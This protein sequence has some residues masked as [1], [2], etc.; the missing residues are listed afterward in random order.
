[1]QLCTDLNML[2]SLYLEHCVFDVTF[3]QSEPIGTGQP[4]KVGIFE[5]GS[6]MDIS[7]LQQRPLIYIQ[8]IKVVIS[9]SGG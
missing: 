3:L 4:S 2:E 5:E 1:M 9:T 8:Y 7:F 6:Y